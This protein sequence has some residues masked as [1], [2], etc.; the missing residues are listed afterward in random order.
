MM[1]C[2]LPQ[3][4]EILEVIDETPNIKTFVL[5]P[6][7]K[8]EFKPGQ[9]VELTVAGVGEAPFAIASSPFQGQLEITIMRTFDP[10]LGRYGQVTS[11]IHQMKAGQVVG[12]RG[13]YGN[14]YPVEASMGKDVLIVGGGIG[15]STLRSFLLTLLQDRKKYGRIVLFYGARTPADLAFRR[16]YESWKQRGAEVHITVDV[17]TAGWTGNVGV[18]TTLF[19][20]VKLD[21]KREIAVV[22]GPPI[23]IRFTVEKL[24][25]VGY[26]PENIYVSLERKMRC[27]IGKCAHCNI[28]H[29]YVCKDGP[30]FSYQQVKDIPEW[31]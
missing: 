2:Y 21:F 16:E 10:S 7:R 31:W 12:I 14:S 8:F 25:Q 3:R 20:R 15:L 19:D 18:V 30:I 11:A 27:G 6:E 5:K 13:P 28:G 23:M 4:A 29:Y 24:L 1:S 22:C 9:F 26:K 17:G